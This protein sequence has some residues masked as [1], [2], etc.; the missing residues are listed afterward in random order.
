MTSDRVYVWTWLADR[1]DPVVAGALDPVG[2]RLHFVYGRSY[3]ERPD[4]VPL[5]LPELPLQP[6]GQPPPDGMD[7]AGC[8]ADGAPDAWGRR[9]ILRRLHAGDSRDVDTAA[10]PAVTYLL[11][12][13]TDRIGAND[14]Q[15]SAETYVPRE[16]HATLEEL[17][18]AADRLQAGE[19]FSEEI[20][21]VL[22]AGSSVGG[23][24]PKATVTAADG[25]A[26]IAKFS[27]P[28]D[29]YPIVKG[30]AVAMELARRADLNV[31]A[32]ERVTVLD[33]D[34]LLVDRF[35]RIPGTR[36][37]RALVSALTLLSLG[38]MYA[39][40]ATYPDLAQTIRTRFTDPQ[41]SL[42]E[43][44][45]RLVFNVLIGNRDDHARNHAAFWDGRDLTLTPAY[46]LDPQPRDTGEATQAMAVT[47]P[48]DR[49]SRLATC[50]DAAG[51]FLLSEPQARAIVD[52]LV[53]TIVD[54]FDDAA[55]TV[56]LTDVDRKLLW[57]RAFL[58]PY[59]FE[60]YG[61]VP[62]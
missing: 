53:Q 40:Y 31:A 39:R 2:D 6:G 36:R 4:A 8:L 3:L 30:E 38:E 13:G 20:D 50:I 51:E 34:V 35:D 46:D 7:L 57:R 22:N 41:A 28:T 14:F 1:A 5:Y 15:A 59:A 23:A 54:E 42:V 58:H 27:T 52:R 48:G 25:R 21:R 32:T 29:T 10:L 61:L 26:L 18:T 9:V 12:S 19:P 56:G 37:R 44:Y 43:L 49:R 24:R 45:G 16:T 55:D 17:L 11:G 47:R 60:D 62:A 33:R